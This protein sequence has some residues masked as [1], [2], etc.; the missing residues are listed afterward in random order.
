MSTD[1]EELIREGIEHITAGAS[2]PAG[3]AARARRRVTRRRRSIR[4]TAV[5]STAMVTAGA[6]LAVTAS[7]PG[8][9]GDRPVQAGHGS[10]PPGGHSAVGPPAVT[11]AYVA[12]R[13]E[14]ALAAAS[15]QQRVEQIHT[16]GRHAW[17]S[18]IV[19]NPSINVGKARFGQTFPA[20]ALGRQLST[21]RMIVWARGGQLRQVGLT[22]DGKRLFDASST[23]SIAP[24]GQRLTSGYGVD[25]KARTW[26]HTVIRDNVGSAQAPPL[27]CNLADLPPPVGSPVDWTTQVHEAL[28]CGLYRPAG[29]QRIDGV[30]AIRLIQARR[31][32]EPGQVPTRETVWVSAATYLPVR[33]TVTWPDGRRDGFITGDFRWLPPTK[34]NLAA[35]RATIPPGFR[36]VKPAGLPEPAYSFIGRSR[37]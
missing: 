29:R 10:E 14:H 13:A 35:L 36:V 4:V 30:E 19:R 5:A 32:A 11:V 7:K 1:I 33:V 18:L 31:P 12:R 20:G 25:Y 27:S 16:V 23:T 37:R 17:F 28:A 15:E 24:A 8:P 34:A 26:W 2:V 9:A 22:A 21:S 6:V 3:L